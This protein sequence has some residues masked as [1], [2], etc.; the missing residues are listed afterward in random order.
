[1]GQPEFIIHGDAEAAV[2]DIFTN[3]TPELPHFPPN[4]PLHISVNML[5]YEAEQRRI[6]VI[7][8]GA[9]ERWPKISRPRIDVEVYAERRSVAKDIAEI[10]LASVK[11]AMGDYSG[12]GL[13]I[14]D[15]RL[16][17]G[18]TRIPDKLQESS[19]YLFSVRLTVTP[20]P[21]SLS[22]AAS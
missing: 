12:F 15:V 9:T 19:R 3:D 21:P 6:V 2:V 16:E 20:S 8:E 22:V 7:Q 1:M 18:I 10:C 4:P 13:F 17:Q 5:G 14:S 11:R